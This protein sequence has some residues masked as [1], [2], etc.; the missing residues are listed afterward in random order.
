MLIVQGTLADAADTVCRGTLPDL[1]EAAV[2]P[3]VRL[4]DDEFRNFVAASAERERYKLLTA[5]HAYWTFVTNE[6][7]TPDRTLVAVL[8]FDVSGCV[9]A[10]GQYSTDRFQSI[11][12]GDPS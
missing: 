5:T 7:H 1:Q 11:T 12:K 3:V 4:T 2:S 9:V 6:D 10:H 8:A